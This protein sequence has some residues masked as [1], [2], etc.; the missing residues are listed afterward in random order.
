MLAI[1]LLMSPF[2]DFHCRSKIRER[3]S[4]FVNSVAGFNGR[5]I[6]FYCSRIAGQR[7]YSRSQ[8]SCSFL[9]QCFTKSKSITVSTRSSQKFRCTENGVVFPN[10]SYGYRSEQ[11]WTPVDVIFLGVQNSPTDYELSILHHVLLHDFLHTCTCILHVWH[12][13][14]SHDTFS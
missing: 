10:Q 3:P 7:F 2:I 14:T 13:F 8:N 9:T 1:F 11:R 5:Q 12:A 4:N 6:F